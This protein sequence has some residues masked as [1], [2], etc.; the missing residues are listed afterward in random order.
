MRVVKNCTI[1]NHAALVPLASRGR[2]FIKNEGSNKAQQMSYFPAVWGTVDNTEAFEGRFWVLEM[3][4]H[5]RNDEHVVF[6]RF[7]K[8]ASAIAKYVGIICWNT[9]EHHLQK[10]KL[11]KVSFHKC[12]KT[13]F[14]T[15][16]S[17]LVK[18]GC[19]TD[20]LCAFSI[21]SI[22]CSIPEKCFSV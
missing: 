21:G 1:P 8:L 13:F 22:G 2:G 14:S 11:F 10:W 5:T 20:M 19:L 6:G 17:S 18:F 3:S 7:G 12:A 15:F 4:S 9:P 16:W